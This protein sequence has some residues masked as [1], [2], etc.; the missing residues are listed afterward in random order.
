M[1][2]RHLEKETNIINRFIEYKEFIKDKQVEFVIKKTERIVYGVYLLSAFIPRTE[3]LHG[4]LKRTTHA[5]LKQAS[6]FAHTTGIKT[7]QIDD[8]HASLQYLSS[9][10][11]LSC[12]SG[13]IS[14]SNIEIFKSEIN[15]LHKHVEELSTKA[16]SES[17][18][19]HVRQDMFVVGQVKQAK[20][21]ATQ[22]TPLK[23][24]E[25]RSAPGMSFIKDKERPQTKPLTPSTKQTE[26]P[27]EDREE[28]IIQVIR[29]KGT[30]SIKDISSVVFDCSEKTIQRTLQTLIDKGQVTKEGERRWAKYS[31]A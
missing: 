18:Q 12:L 13:Y 15:Y 1:D 2:K 20:P 14:E 25:A 24:K 19:M 22:Q 21:Q 3:V 31:L 11:S 26:M 29:D 8:V 7:T 4:D 10:L 17:Q 28:K 23:D 9:L 6:Q 5:L 30:V 16:V 27:K